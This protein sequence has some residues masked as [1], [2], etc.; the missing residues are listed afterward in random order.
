[1]TAIATKLKAEGEPLAQWP[2]STVS[3]PTFCTSS[4]SLAAVRST[5]GDS[6]LVATSNPARSVYATTVG[7]VGSYAECGWHSSSYGY[8]NVSLLAGGSWALPTLAPQAPG[9]ADYG[10]APYVSVPAQGVTSDKVSCADGTC[11]AFLAVGTSAVEILYNDPG[12]AKNPTV[13]A[14]FAKVI[15]AS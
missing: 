4:T 13:L 3:P 7:L 10:T 2:G 15:A 11:D 9:D 1:M 14:A 8:L 12:V 5:V 6:T